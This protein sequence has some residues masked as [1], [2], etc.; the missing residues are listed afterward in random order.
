MNAADGRYSAAQKVSR[1]ILRIMAF[2][3]SLCAGPFLEAQSSSSTN[4]CI[5][6]LFFSSG[7]QAGQRLPAGATDPNF[8]GITPNFPPSQAAFVLGSVPAVWIGGSS[9][10]GPQWIGPSP[11]PH[12]QPPD[13]FVYRVI[14]V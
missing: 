11:D 12:V 13:T 7:I 9:S 8:K 6:S 10:S 4:G 3:G 5:S 1:S 2:T 14:F